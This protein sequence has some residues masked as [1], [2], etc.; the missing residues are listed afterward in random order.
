MVPGV[1][2]DR[3]PV[4]AA[5]WI[6]GATYGRVSSGADGYKQQRCLGGLRTAS[7]QA[8]LWDERRDLQKTGL[9][10]ELET[11]QTST[12]E[13]MT[14]GVAANF[15]ILP[16]PPPFFKKKNKN[17]FFYG[18]TLSGLRTSSSSSTSFSLPSSIVL[19]LPELL[20]FVSPFVALRCPSTENFLYRST[21][22]N[23]VK[24]PTET[25]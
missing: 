6:W 1:H 17:L 21:K 4:S 11:P 19:P 12:H 9:P 16:I 10:Y 15:R 25:I 18:L 3:L 2:A 13:S 5:S 24:N 20:C 7:H 22:Q 8:P 14:L 23:I